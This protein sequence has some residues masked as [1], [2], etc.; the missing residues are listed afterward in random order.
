MKTQT[1]SNPEEHQTTKSMEMTLSP[2]Q[3]YESVDYRYE[4]SGQIS[5]LGQDEVIYDTPVV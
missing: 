2:N 1:A 5:R 4:T 3:A